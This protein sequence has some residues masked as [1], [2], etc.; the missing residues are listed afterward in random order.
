MPPDSI[1]EKQSPSDR[2]PVVKDD[3][4]LPCPEVFGTTDANRAN[5]DPSD[6]TQ[7]TYKYE[8]SFSQGSD[9][10]TGRKRSR[11]ASPELSYDDRRGH[12][13]DEHSGHEYNVR[14][15]LIDEDFSEFGLSLGD[16]FDWD[17]YIVPSVTKELK[18]IGDKV[19]SMF[20][21]NPTRWASYDKCYP[22][23][24]F[25]P[26]FDVEGSQNEEMEAEPDPEATQS[27]TD[28]QRE[29]HR[30]Q[31]LL[32]FCRQFAKHEGVVMAIYKAS[33]PP[34]T[35]QPN[36]MRPSPGMDVTLHF[37]PNDSKVVTSG[38]PF[39]LN[40]VVM[41]VPREGE[42][43]RQYGWLLD[44]NRG[45][46][47]SVALIKALKLYGNH[48][49][50]GR[51]LADKFQVH[52]KEKVRNG[53]VE[54]WSS[55]DLDGPYEHD[56]SVFMLGVDMG[57]TGSAG[58]FSHYS[59]KPTLKRLQASGEVESPGSFG[60][61]ESKR[62]RLSDLVEQGNASDKGS[63]YETIY[64]KT[65]R[66]SSSLSQNDSSPNA[67]PQ[68]HESALE[69]YTMYNI[70]TKTLS[71]KRD[72]G[73]EV[74][75]AQDGAGKSTTGTSDHGMESDPIDLTFG[76]MEAYHQWIGLQEGSEDE[77]G[78]EE[79]LEVES[80]I[81]PIPTNT[82]SEEG[83]A[84][85][86]GEEDNGADNAQVA[87]LEQLVDEMV[88][89][90]ESGLNDNS[91]IAPSIIPSRRAT[92]EEEDPVEDRR[93][94]TGTRSDSQDLRAD[95]VRD[96][97][98]GGNTSTT[99]HGNQSGD[100]AGS[101]NIQSTTPIAAFPPQSKVRMYPID[102]D[103][104]TKYG[105]VNGKCCDVPRFNDDGSQ[106]IAS[107]CGS[108]QLIFVWKQK[109]GIA[110][111]AITD[112]FDIIREP[113]FNKDHL[114]LS[115]TTIKNMRGQLPLPEI[116]GERVEVDATKA[117]SKTPPEV[118]QYT[119]NIKEL[120]ERN[121]NNPQ[122][123]EQCHF[124]AAV[125]SAR[126][127]EAYD[128]DLWKGS[129][130]A[131]LDMY[132]LLTKEILEPSQIYPGGCYEVDCCDTFNNLRDLLVRAVGLF[133][134]AK[135]SDEIM[136]NV[137]P[138]ITRYED[139]QLLGLEAYADLFD[140][141]PVERWLETDEASNEATNRDSESPERITP[142]TSNSASK[143][144]SSATKPITDDDDADDANL[145][146]SPSRKRIVLKRCYILKQ[147]Y[148]V[149]VSRFKTAVCMEI[150][151]ADDNLDDILPRLKI[152]RR[153]D[154]LPTKR[155]FD[156]GK[157]EEDGSV[158]RKRKVVKRKGKATKTP[159]GRANAGRGKS[160][161]SEKKMSST[162]TA[163]TNRRIRDDI[164][165]QHDHDHG[166]TNGTQE[167]TEM[168][169]SEEQEDVREY[170]SLTEDQL[171]H[172]VSESMTDANTVTITPANG[173]V[174]THIVQQIVVPEK[175]GTVFDRNLFLRGLPTPKGLS[176]RPGQ[177]TEDPDDLVTGTDKTNAGK[178]K[179]AKQ[180]AE[181]K[182]KR[183]ERIAARASKSTGKYNHPK[184]KEAIDQLNLDTDN[185][186]G[187]IRPTPVIKM[188]RLIAAGH[189][190]KT[191]AELEIEKGE[192]DL[193]ELK[194]EKYNP[195]AGTLPRL[196][197]VIDLYS[198]KFGVF[199][200]AHRTTGGIYMTMLNLDYRGRDQ[201]RNHTLCGFIP[202]GAK[203]SETGQSLLEQIAVL[204]KGVVMNVQGQQTKV[205]VKLLSFNGDMEEA[206]S[207]AGVGGAT[208]RTGCRFCYIPSCNL[209]DTQLLQKEW[210]RQV[211]K[212]QMHICE[213]I[214]ML[215]IQDRDGENG[216]QINTDLMLEAGLLPYVPI[217]SSY[218]PAFDR[219]IQIAMDI[220]HIEQKGLGEMA[221]SRLF[222]KLLSKDGGLIAFNNEFHR[223]KFP[224][225]VS[226]LPN[227]TCHSRSLQMRE[228]ST[229][230]ACIPFLLK[231]IQ[232]NVDD[233]FEIFDPPVL[234]AYQ[235]LFPEEGFTHK[236]LLQYVIEVYSAIAKA[237]K[238]IFSRVMIKDE[239]EW[240]RDDYDELEKV[241]FE[242]R[243]M[244]DELY[245]PFDKVTPALKMSTLGNKY[246]QDPRGGIL[247]RL[248][249]FHQALHMRS[250]AIYFGTNLV[251]SCSIGELVHKLWKQMVPHT[252]Y[253]E[254]DREFCKFWAT[255]DSLRYL[256]DGEIDHPWTAKLL[257]FRK[258]LPGLF[259]GY[260]FGHMARQSEEGAWVTNKTGLAS[261]INLMKDLRFP[262]IFFGAPIPFKV[263][264][265]QI[266]YPT[267]LLGR[268]DDD[269]AIEGLKLAYQSYQ[270]PEYELDLTV[271]E[272]VFVPSTGKTVTHLARLQW[273]E[274]V[275]YYDTI[276]E[277]RTR[278]RL[279]DFIT[280]DEVEKRRL[281]VS[282]QALDSGMKNTYAKVLGIC[283]HR[284]KGI[285]Y[286][287]LFVQWL[288]TQARLKD[289]KMAD[290]EIYDLAPITRFDKR[291]WRNFIAL[292]AISAEK[293][294]YFVPFETR[295][296]NK[297]ST[298]GINLP[299]VSYD[300]T[301]GQWTTEAD[302]M[303]RLRYST[304]R[305]AYYRNDWFF[306][307]M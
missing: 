179:K 209:D 146:S 250:N 168:L 195:P 83:A 180:K 256:I 260:F 163:L 245:R 282:Y 218:G 123:F 174:P 111:N 217:I 270:I 29:A 140:F 207:L 78:E 290:I 200:T 296:K 19:Y 188:D 172:I 196:G 257:L 246:M 12:C 186:L 227:P 297:G 248:P 87:M 32:G 255:M 214:R 122:I 307:S 294:P 160:R 275:S 199:R 302:T 49:I 251:T 291:N 88:L 134:T 133:R 272:D 13:I 51:I 97:T 147:E 154:R 38:N 274:S 125:D 79:G 82:H 8:A 185:P 62:I 75:S 300:D 202:H 18:V 85:R 216:A 17:G 71:R 259:C 156:N 232:V 293:S 145:S 80:Q 144:N 33:R 261:R 240:T 233:S 35:S 201:C 181:Q 242:S 301:E 109:H 77:D 135:G 198:D 116:M 2:P 161:P 3:P 148:R 170:T 117:D 107:D 305:E 69:T 280:V 277:A 94:E 92:V 281:G 86:L 189:I 48:A 121:L 128:G 158:K 223:Y 119:F 64:H 177:S 127:L 63:K 226:R 73:I 164:D 155:D 27:Q 173:G 262:D 129:I 72:T 213:R 167:D 25:Q 306:D 183:S 278:L 143:I 236:T 175:L 22:I 295:R 247:R 4:E 28:S 205:H 68:P 231:E 26:K 288:Q 235:A 54:E 165:H 10:T 221:I 50:I 230:L 115:P 57:P 273:W 263:A 105:L 66:L 39:M 182:K 52:N 137:Q 114:P 162:Q 106:I 44:T 31:P 110:D 265:D 112:L 212:R 268:K 20:K 151:R 7:H 6:M 74:I 138:I 267:V 90:G 58:R 222:N 95:E 5:I 56:S 130:T 269:M 153:G 228:V 101:N 244:F 16:N 15:S 34:S 46:L 40:V 159:K 224:N 279:G 192:I 14:K 113:Y 299:S 220:S 47:E 241:V 283:T 126:R 206:N 225:T 166:D 45:N 210:E 152:L 136:A 276:S 304:R 234:K 284:V 264:K 157:V 229:L 89:S 176:S 100:S 142:I 285:N 287:F 303:P 253:Y 254:L 84:Q 37:V 24:N 81:P 194:K 124:G 9:N 252:N 193:S 289:R 191:T 76:D 286:V 102:K 190:R 60:R 150:D 243:R 67:G 30:L 98:D 1:D 141:T 53:Q 55:D 139:L 238:H 271:S 131:C 184:L 169:E 103:D 120:I 42:L 70:I 21:V 93:A 197:V 237:N 298:T 149:L 59:N 43:Q 108:R 203:F 23:A 211:I 266:Q 91:S 249:N 104:L 187:R 219:S 178:K 239:D 258:R 118:T 11:I 65:S 215:A 61:Y 171:D 36:P 99:Q 132:P 41:D 208:S 96:A 204:A 292:P